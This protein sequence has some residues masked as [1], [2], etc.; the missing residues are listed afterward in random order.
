VE[1]K[2]SVQTR[3]ALAL[4]IFACY[5]AACPT[6]SAGVIYDNGPFNGGINAFAIDINDSQAVSN[7]FTLSGAADITAVDFGVWVLPGDTPA[8]VEGLITSTDFGGT[9]YGDYSVSLSESLDPL[10]PNSFGFDLYDVSFSVPD[11]GLAAGTYYLTLQNADTTNPG[12]VVLWDEN[13]GPSTAF[14]AT[15]I[16]NDPGPGYTYSDPCALTDPTCNPADVPGGSE[17][18]QIE[19]TFTPEPGTTYLL[20]G[21]F[22]LLA[23]AGRGLSARRSA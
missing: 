10:S 15:I 1:V 13:D 4:S 11:L 21:G 3:A 16:P 9:I 12:D 20:L 23:I 17:T 6:A 5:F 7:S 8:S 2:K 19:G 18:F 14:L 22:L